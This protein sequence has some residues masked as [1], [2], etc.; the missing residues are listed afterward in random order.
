M[1]AGDIKGIFRAKDCRLIYRLPFFPKGR[2]YTVSDKLPFFSLL[3][4]GIFL[5]KNFLNH[6]MVFVIKFYT[7]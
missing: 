1:L 2:F 6:A 5:K 7:V 4:L 3:Y